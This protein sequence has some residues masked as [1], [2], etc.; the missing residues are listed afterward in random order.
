MITSPVKD[1][2]KSHI[3]STSHKEQFQLKKRGFQKELENMGDKKSPVYLKE[4]PL[5]N[6][7]CTDTFCLLLFLVLFVFQIFLFINNQAYKF[8][9]LKTISK[10]HD[11]DRNKIYYLYNKNI[12]IFKKDRTCGGEDRVNY[13][14]IYFVS[15]TPDTL[16]RTVCVKHCPRG[17]VTRKEKEDFFL[18][19]HPNSNVTSCDYTKNKYTTPYN[20]TLLY[21]TYHCI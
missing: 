17:L 5:P 3:H 4:G 12:F 19:C 7:S 14:Y 15:P 16:D 11:Y 6:R 18:Q 10:A 9:P 13:N 1:L 21:D 20:Q 8:N 2:E